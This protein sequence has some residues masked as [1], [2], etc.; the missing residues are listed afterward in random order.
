MRQFR[1]QGFTLIEILLV[2]AVLAII[3]LF[4]MRFLHQNSQ[5]QE[6]NKVALSMQ[7]VVEAA[8]AYN[9]DHNGS[10]PTATSTPPTCTPNN[11][12]SDFIQ[13]YLPNYN[14]NDNK[15][16]VDSFGQHYCWSEST[17]N[18]TN[19]SRLFW[20]A[21]AIPHA[22]AKL[23]ARIAALLPNAIT[24]S[25]PSN[26]SAPEACDSSACYVRVEVPQP[27]YG[28]TSQNETFIGSGECSPNS[29]THSGI[30]ECS[31][32]TTATTATNSYQIT[33]PACP[34][35]YQANITVS[36]GNINFPWRGTMGNS[37]IGGFS[38]SQINS[39]ATCSQ[40]IN[41]NQ[42]QSCNANVTVSVVTSLGNTSGNYHSQNINTIQNSSGAYGSAG[43]NYTIFCYQQSPKTSHKS[44][45]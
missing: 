41:P 36:P 39:S 15:N 16:T 21:V 5:E 13:Y 44:F 11:P 33:F 10:W 22:N 6:A 12:S 40:M 19:P 27:G 14:A 18:G 3:T 9:A 31:P 28:L 4:S 7:H 24:T 2:I 35:G 1:Q 20:V 45:L 34:A 30:I 32:I 29:T 26:T 8:L 23:A 17:S 25:D 43:L 42:Q 38:P 37:Y